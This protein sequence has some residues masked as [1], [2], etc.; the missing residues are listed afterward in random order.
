MNIFLAR[1]FSEKTRGIVIASASLLC[2][3]PAAHCRV[4]RRRRAKTFTFCSTIKVI[5]PTTVKLQMWIH[6]DEF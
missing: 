1:L 5:P 2:R 3:Q 6:L 4:V